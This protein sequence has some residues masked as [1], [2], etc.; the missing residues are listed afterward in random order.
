MWKGLDN[1]K[2]TYQDNELGWASRL[3][4]TLS[5]NKDTIMMTG[6]TRSG[7]TTMLT[8]LDKRRD[9]T[10]E[11][12]RRDTTEDVYR[13]GYQ[14]KTGKKVYIKSVDTAGLPNRVNSEEFSKLLNK[15]KYFIF[16]INVD[17]FLGGID[18]NSEKETIIKWFQ[19]I[20]YHA[21]RYNRNLILVLSHADQYLDR[22]G[23]AYTEENKYSEIREKFFGKEGIISSISNCDVK[24]EIA[25]V[26]I[27]DE[28]RGIIDK[29]I[30]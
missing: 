27:Y 4:R 5:F 22:I 23:K 26:H 21:K 17:S 28:V 24:D 16:L 1:M 10:D 3:W 11:D 29:L 2:N 30:S 12:V 19:E 20:Y 8:V 6:Y 15:H 9:V 25:N 13:I 7:K 18:K 14:T